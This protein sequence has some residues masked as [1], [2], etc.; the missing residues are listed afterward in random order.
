M[1]CVDSG[2][3]KKKL[4]GANMGKLLTKPQGARAGSQVDNI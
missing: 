3:E 2:G 4:E 1:K